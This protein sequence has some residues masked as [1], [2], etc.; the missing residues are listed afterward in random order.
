MGMGGDVGAPV[1][2]PPHTHCCTATH[3][4]NPTPSP[5]VP[6][7]AENRQTHTHSG[8][9]LLPGGGDGDYPHVPAVILVPGGEE[10]VEG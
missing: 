9:A 8:G 5:D 3:A 4:Q 2:P 7:G 6:H 10:E 1:P